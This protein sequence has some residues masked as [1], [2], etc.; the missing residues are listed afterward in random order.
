MKF[1][2]LTLFVASTFAQT[3]HPPNGWPDDTTITESRII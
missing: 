3:Q 2:A 1:L